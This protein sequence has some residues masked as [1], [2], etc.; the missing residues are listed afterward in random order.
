MATLILQPDATT[1]L[2]TYISSAN[3]TFNYGASAVLA[4]CFSSPVIRPLLKFDIS[5]IPAN[6][7][8]TSA[9]LT[10]KNSAWTFS[11]TL[12]F[13]RVTTA[14]FEGVQNGAAPAAGQNGSTWNLRNANG[15]VAWTAGP[16]G[17]FA[18]QSGQIDSDDFV[19]G[20]LNSVDLTAD[21]KAFYAGTL[22][23]NGWTFNS[24]GGSVNAFNFDSSDSATAANRPK[25]TIV[26]ELNKLVTPTPRFAVAGRVNPTVVKGAVSLAATPTR[27]VG[28]VAG[29]AI[30]SGHTLSVPSADAIADTSAAIVIGGMTFLGGVAAARA[31]ASTIVTVGGMTFLGGVA[32]AV[33]GRAN[34]A[35]AHAAIMTPLSATVIAVRLGPTA[36]LK[37]DP[38]LTP[39]AA[40][41]RGSVFGPASLV[42]LTLRPAAATAYV[43]TV[44]RTVAYRIFP[45][46]CTP[47]PLLY[48][49]DGTLRDNG[50]MERLNLI[51]PKL[52][53]LL[54]NWLPTIAQYKSGG[55]FSDSAVATGRRL[56]RRVFANAVEVLELAGKSQDQDTMIAFIRELIS[57]QEMASD[58]WVSDWAQRPVYLVA[59]AAR[60]TETR[61]AMIHTMSVPELQNPYAQPFYGQGLRSALETVTLRIERGDWTSTPPGVADGVGVSSQRTWT[62][63]GWTA[64]GSGGSGGSGSETITGS[65][66]CLIQA[67]NGD[68]LAGTNDQ[69]KIYRSTDSGVTWLQVAKLGSGA[70]SV[71]GFAKTSSGA[72]FAA[73]TGSAAVKGIWKSTSNGVTWTRSL[74][75]SSGQGYRDI[76][77]SIQQGILGAGG[78]SDVASLKNVVLSHNE[79]AA[80]YFPISHQSA[81]GAIAVA[82][83]QEPVLATAYPGQTSSD[84]FNKSGA[85]FVGFDT[86]YTI[87]GVAYQTSNPITYDQYIPGSGQMGN[88]G[89][90][91]NVF[92]YKNSSGSYYRKALWAVK[93]AFDTTD[94]EIWQ[95]PN[96]AGGFN[97]GKLTTIDSKIFNVLYTDPVP[98]Q[99]IPVQRTIW[100]GGNGEIWVSYNSGLTWTVATTVPVNQIR[101]LLRTTSGMLIAGGDAGEIFLYS[102]S[103]GSQG[104]GVGDVNGRDV[105]SHSAPP[106]TSGGGSTVINAYPLGRSETSKDEVFVANGST[107]SNITHVLYYNGSVY[108]NLQFST[109]PPYAL[110]GATA[111]VNKAAYFGS[112]TANLNVPG[113]TFTS[114][115]FDISRIAEN[116]TVVWEYWNG[117]AWTA[118]TV[119]DTTT[120][121]RTDGV[122]S[123]HWMIPANWATTTVNGVL[124]Y[125]VRVRTTVVS[126][127]SVTPLHDRRYIYTPNLPYGEMAV[128]AVNGD[129][130][131]LAQIRWHNRSDNPAEAGG[132]GLEVDRVI[133]GLRSVQRGQYFNPYL[134]ISDTQVPYGITVIK[135]AVGNWASSLRAPTNRVFDIVS[136]A[137]LNTWIDL[138]TFS[139]SNTVARDYYGTYRAFVRGY[140]YGAGTSY[141]QV[142]LRTSFG[143]GGSISDSR[144][145]QVSGGD[146]EL[147]DLGQ[148]TVPTTQ[149]SPLAG[150]LGDLL[151]LTVQ[152]YAPAASLQMDLYD[153]ILIPTDEWAV[154]ARTPT[155]S[156]SINPTKVIGDS[157]LD[158][159]SITNPKTLITATNRNASDLIVSRYQAIAN[160]P[161]ILQT[162]RQQRLWFVTS[163]FYNGWWR[164]FPEIVGSV[165][166]FKQQRYLAYRGTS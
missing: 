62:V 128:E 89:L 41:A 3:P 67:N 12:Q 5:S 100:A 133:C 35:I 144:A 107:F 11:P 109:L 156:G 105:S 88:R 147:I 26:Y 45:V 80:W 68:V 15:S 46:V 126:A 139:I 91:M 149:V 48:I 27:A 138:V 59:K 165:Q 36:V 155:P 76:T 63:T 70:D 151:K 39:P 152:G 78:G 53:F 58:Y 31:D 118:L 83:Q 29:P 158:L 140:R 112:Q 129:L 16:G 122:G 17:D 81:Y 6:A 92:L 98:W 69:A 86:Y 106:M 72:I 136:G 163:S 160:G 19:G 4:M 47:E 65:I 38:Y 82:G 2:D 20:G 159:D 52:G 14:W 61:Y 60:E 154:D 64:G 119:R 104:G 84:P 166:V 90:D 28:D 108:S 55:I 10:I 114:L 43:R 134:N 110:L 51:D 57:W 23:N 164:S 42:D 99:T 116:M 66:L 137:T 148:I 115:V 97:F 77:F 33:A 125:W 113:G 123:V 150:N 1:G 120:G 161:A 8:I 146:W 121:F 142:R 157:F 131:A 93:S 54:K 37:T 132:L 127:S 153:L 30:L 71:N 94:T 162:R 103:S 143:S 9:I 79:G 124:G 25:L 87:A 141:W 49:T 96:P 18:A 21:V 73:L 111:A 95:W 44:G 34:P 32:G 24:Q 145:V 102:G 135:S 75:D 74:D 13:F 101:S 85:I 40:A 50:Q 130:P 117:A 22:V 56:T 7:A